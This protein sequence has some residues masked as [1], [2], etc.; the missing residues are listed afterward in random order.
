MRYF[1]KLAY[2]GTEFHGWQRQEDAFSVQQEIEEKLSTILRTETPVTGCGRT[3]TGVHAKEYY[4]HFDSE[5]IEMDNSLFI[6]KLNTML[7][8]GI[9]IQEIILVNSDAHARFDATKRSYEYIITSTK[10]PFLQ[11]KAYRFSQELN[12]P[13]MN[14]ACER[15][16]GVQDFGCFCK[17]R[18]DNHTNICTVFSAGWTGEADMIRFNI[19]ANRFLRNMVRAIVGT[20]LE[21][22]QGR[23]GLNDFDTILRSKDRQAAGRSVPA[24]GLYLTQV[25]YPSHIFLPTP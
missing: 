24:Q 9:V 15:L 7:H 14:K 13:A 4:A 1:L 5:P 10:D 6:Y 19:T 17:S 2:D 22:G 8:W 20:M 11:N 25:D 21:I 23:I 3:D 16:L 12:L 18:A